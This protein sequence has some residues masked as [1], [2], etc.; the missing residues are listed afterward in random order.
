[1]FLTNRVISIEITTHICFETH[2]NVTIFHCETNETNK[3]VFLMM[4]DRISSEERAANTTLW[5]PRKC[6]GSC[7][8][9]S[10]VTHLYGLYLYPFNL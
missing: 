1:M 4:M 7:Y 5:C 2:M 9:S 3:L 10:A 8:V 6:I